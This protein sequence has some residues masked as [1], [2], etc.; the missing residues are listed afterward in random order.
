LAV[1]VFKPPVAKSQEWEAKFT[2]RSSVTSEGKLSSGT[3]RGGKKVG[4]TEGGG[5]GVE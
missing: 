4:G 2:A 5:V 1:K 3:G